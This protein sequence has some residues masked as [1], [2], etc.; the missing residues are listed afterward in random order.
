MRVL[1]GLV[2]GLCLGLLVY[3]VARPQSVARLVGWDQ[4]ESEEGG[5][6]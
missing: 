5:E 1:L 2:D 3:A 4:S 6:E